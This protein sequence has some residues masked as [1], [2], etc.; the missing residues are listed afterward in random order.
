MADINF[1]K[2]ALDRLLSP[3]ELDQ[4]V[5]VTTPKAWIALAMIAVMLLGL[6]IWS[7]VGHL[8]TRVTANGLLFTQGGRVVD[9][10]ARATGSVQEIRFRAG[11]FVAENEVV[12]IIEMSELQERLTSVRAELQRWRGN[13]EDTRSQVEE[14]RR[15]QERN[16]AEREDRLMTLLELSQEKIGT[17]RKRLE[18][19]ERLFEQQVTTRL[20][21]ENARQTLEQALSEEIGIR[22]NLDDL[23]ASELERRNLAARRIEE[24]EARYDAAQ[25]SLAEIET[26]LLTGSQIRAPLSGRVTE[27]KTAEGSLVGG[28]TPIMSIESL[29]EGIE[30]IA[31]ISPD[32]GKQVMAGMDALVDPV[33]VAKEEYGALRGNVKGVSEFPVTLEGMV[34]VLQNRDLAQTFAQ[35]GPPYEARIDL[36]PDPETESGY[37][38]TSKR[39]NDQALTSG[40]LVAVEITTEEK[41]PITLVIPLLK[42]LSG[43]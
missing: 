42:E 26:S 15:L 30:V 16:V 14:E 39:G 5:R 28:G 7:V 19:Y 2:A 10:S 23:K 20:V 32:K 36:V 4:A 9:A 35:L 18:E 31:Y 24:A 17:A 37:A 1:R 34:A 40:T 22:N 6:I 21:L 41:A 27:I 12:A 29:G 11:D 38:W 43:L 25:R 33:T 13:L 3:E 8:S